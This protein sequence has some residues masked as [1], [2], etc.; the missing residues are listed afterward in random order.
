MDEFGS[1][2]NPASGYFYFFRR[3][4]KKSQWAKRR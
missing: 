2:G 1:D 4:R 3:L